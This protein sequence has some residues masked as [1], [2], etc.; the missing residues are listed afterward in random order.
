[1]DDE[2]R[3]RRESCLL[4]ACFAYHTRVQAER[5]RNWPSKANA[6]RKAEAAAQRESRGELDLEVTSRALRVCLLLA[7]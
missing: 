7:C 5:A 2:Y 1:M 3:V 4:A 6:E